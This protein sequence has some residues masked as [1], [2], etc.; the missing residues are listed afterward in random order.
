MFKRQMARGF[1]MEE[2]EK[3]NKFLPVIIKG[4]GLSI[5]FALIFVLIFAFIIQTFSL[6]QAT[7]KI[8]NQFIKVL[9]I[10]LSCFVCIRG[11]LGLIKG[12][13]IGIN[14]III[15][16]LI[17]SLIGSNISFTLSFIIDIVFGLVVG[18]LS[19]IIAVN[20]KKE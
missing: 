17:F 2:L 5:I 19:G 15:T 10:F 7:I 16:T 4:T 9:A 6:T 8:V 14:A 12:A 13:F 11:K 3:E 20:M 18:S 1:F